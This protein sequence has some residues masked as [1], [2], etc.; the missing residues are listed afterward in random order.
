MCGQEV[1]LFLQLNVWG[2]R[3]PQQADMIRELEPGF[4]QGER[5]GVKGGADSMNRVLLQTLVPNAPWKRKPRGWGTH[6]GIF[7]RGMLSGNSKQ[8]LASDSPSEKWTFILVCQA[9]GAL[10][11][12]W[13]LLDLRQVAECFHIS[14]FPVEHRRT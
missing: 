11:D 10:K 12:L 5:D 13:V 8:P 6:V 1:G 4:R 3:S 14:V 9:P 7:V 2:P